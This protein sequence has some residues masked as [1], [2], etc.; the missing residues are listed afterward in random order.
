MSRIVGRRLSDE[1]FLSALVLNSDPGKALEPHDARYV[2]CSEARHGPPLVDTL[3]RYIRRMDAAPVLPGQN[4][5]ARGSVVQLLCGHRGCGKTT[6]LKRLKANLEDG[7]NGGRYLVCLCEADLYFDLLHASPA[8]VLFALVQR[9]WEDLRPLGIQLRPPDLE[10]FADEFLNL[11]LSPVEFQ[12]LEVDAKLVKLSAVIRERP[13]VRLVVQQFLGPRAQTVKAAINEVL[14]QAEA[15]LQR[16]KYQGVVFI[17]DNLDRISRA[18]LDDSGQPLQDTLFRDGAKTLGGLRSHVIYTVPPALRYDVRAAQLQAA[19]G[20]QP[21]T[22][23][24]MIPT[25]HRDG[26]PDEAGLERLRDIVR[27]RLAQCDPAAVDG[28]F[29]SDET[30]ARL[31]RA[32]GGFVRHLVSLLRGAANYSDRLP[33]ERRAVEQ[34]IVDLR[35]ELS[36]GLSAAGRRELLKKVQNTREIEE[37]EE[38]AALLE[39]FVILEYR[40]D[41]G[42][43]YDVHPLVQE[44]L[45][46]AP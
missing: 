40:S 39:A 6:E 36:P 29:D 23:L 37:A 13:N 24:P 30:L 11:L 41:F 14:E 5:A 18:C 34:A 21:A 15:A 35:S 43:W 16:K 19:L 45:R 22:T 10:R 26:S 3:A 1:E 46:T 32:S 33:I 12:K 38:Y 7:G 31:C 27:R 20:S 4:P 25:Q 2:D 42:P 17:V 28:A 9:L 8:Q 44:I